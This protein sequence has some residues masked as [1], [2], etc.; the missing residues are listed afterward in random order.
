MTFPPFAKW[1]R[2]L[3]CILILFGCSYCKDHQ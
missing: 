3:P 2:Q 1:R